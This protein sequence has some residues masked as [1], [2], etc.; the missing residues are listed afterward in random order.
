MTN[1]QPRKL[2]KVIARV[3]PLIPDEHAELRDHLDRIARGSGFTAPEMMAQ[4]WCKAA[5]ALA[6]ALPEGSTGRP[7]EDALVAIWSGEDVLPD[8]YVE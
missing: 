1:A 4:E 8:D 2:H 5:D 6:E 7:W 3:L